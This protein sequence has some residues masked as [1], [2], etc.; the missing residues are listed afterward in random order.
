MENGTQADGQILSNATSKAALNVVQNAHH[1][2]A[3]SDVVE[4]ETTEDKQKEDYSLAPESEW[5][6]KADKRFNVRKLDEFR[7]RRMNRKIRRMNQEKIK[8][9]V[10]KVLRKLGI[11]VQKKSTPLE[12]ATVMLSF[13]IRLKR[14]EEGCFFNNVHICWVVFVVQIKRRN[15]DVKRESKCDTKEYTPRTQIVYHAVQAEPPSREKTLRKKKEQK[16]KDKEA[17]AKFST[18]GEIERVYTLTTEDSEL[19]KF[20]RGDLDDLPLELFDHPEYEK[21]C[22]KDWLAQG[23]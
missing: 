17:A 2:H 22:L 12:T 4:N 7:Q 8:V 3:Q 6:T 21:K 20:S 10:P 15:G 18:Q 9:A 13:S 19:Y 1:T 5:R 11:G 14:R 23:G 16:Q